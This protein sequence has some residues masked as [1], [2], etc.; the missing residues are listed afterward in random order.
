MASFDVSDGGCPQFGAEL[1]LS[2]SERL[3]KTAHSSVADPADID[4][5]K[6]FAPVLCDIGDPFRFERESKFARWCGTGAVA[7]STGEGS[8]E[9]A[10]HRLDFGGNCRINSVLYTIAA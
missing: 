10:R 2:H 8:N 4:L 1:A 9:T 7:I 5:K 3:V 6:R